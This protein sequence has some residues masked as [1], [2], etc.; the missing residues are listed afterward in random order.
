MSNYQGYL[1]K[2]GNTVIPNSYFIEY[3][4]TPNQRLD[5]EEDNTDNTGKLRRFVLKHTRS[6]IA[7]TVRSLTLS[8]KIAFQNLIG[9]GITNSRERKATV[10]YWNDESNSYSQG[11]FYIPDITFTVDDA[12]SNTIRYQP[13][14]YELI[15]Y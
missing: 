3:S 2:F 5:S 11:E 6:R 13:F 12:D 4:S 9:S 15:E 14:N 7:F 8:E 10:T 1:L